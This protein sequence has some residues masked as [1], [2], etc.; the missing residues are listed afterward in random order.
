MWKSLYF[1]LSY[2]LGT[3]YDWIHF[4]SRILWKKTSEDYIYNGCVCVEYN[5][6]YQNLGLTDDNLHLQ[7]VQPLLNSVESS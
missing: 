4:T 2:V 5:E 3:E 7:K 6:N 1:V